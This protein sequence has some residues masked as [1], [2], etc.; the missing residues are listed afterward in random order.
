MPGSC[1]CRLR[2]RVTSD[3]CR[4][5]ERR[6]PENVPLRGRLVNIH[7]SAIVS[8]RAKIGK[9][10]RIGPFSIVESGVTIGHGCRLDGRVVLKRGTTLGNDN[11]LFEGAVLGGLPHGPPYCRGRLESFSVPMAPGGGLAGHD[12]LPRPFDAY[13]GPD[14]TEYP[15][16]ID[17]V[18]SPSGHLDLLA[19]REKLIARIDD[20]VVGELETSEGSVVLA[21]WAVGEANV[22]RWHRQA[23]E[24]TALT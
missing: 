2:S 10:V 9:D 3:A 12:A 1:D 14:G 15:D 16:L 11:M 6:S 23:R 19:T 5:S 24:I 22:E 4:E 17:V 8:P 21:Q 13:R 20:E 7:P 18:A